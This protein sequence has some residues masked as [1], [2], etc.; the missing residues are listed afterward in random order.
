[1]RALS[2]LRLAPVMQGQQHANAASV[3]AKSGSGSDPKEAADM[4]R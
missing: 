3:E 4:S 2:A 1:M